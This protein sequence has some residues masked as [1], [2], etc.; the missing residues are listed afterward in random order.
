MRKQSS[1]LSE[2]LAHASALILRSRVSGVSK[3]G[4]VPSRDA[5]SFETVTA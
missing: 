5:L 3:E 4:P 1:D 2:R